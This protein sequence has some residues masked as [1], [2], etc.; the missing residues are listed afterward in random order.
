VSHAETH[1]VLNCCYTVVSDA[2]LKCCKTLKITI[3][4]VNR[5]IIDLLVQIIIVSAGAEREVS[6]V[7]HTE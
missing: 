4:L 3:L 5:K 1:C 7:S 2:L 6:R